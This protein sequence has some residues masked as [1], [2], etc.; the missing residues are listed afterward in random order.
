MRWGILIKIDQVL[1]FWK[2]VRVGNVKKIAGL[3]E[4]SDYF[5]SRCD[6]S[7]I[8]PG[9]HRLFQDMPQGAFPTP[10]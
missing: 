1:H 9:L 8:F 2:E 7:L 3:G 4:A 10:S 6:E 5:P